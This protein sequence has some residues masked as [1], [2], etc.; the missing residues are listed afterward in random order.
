M[1]TANVLFT[2]NRDIWNEY[3]KLKDKEIKFRAQRILHVA[4]MNV[5]LKDDDDDIFG[6]SERTPPVDEVEYI[7]F[8]KEI[9]AAA[10][11]VETEDAVLI[12]NLKDF[13]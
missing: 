5:P 13:K 1:G 9:I 6:L 3:V 11:A 8:Q 2:L 12:L 10:K 4:E 7:E